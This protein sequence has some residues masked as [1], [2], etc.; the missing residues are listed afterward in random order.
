MTRDQVEGEAVVAV[1]QR[2]HAEEAAHLQGEEDPGVDEPRGEAVA[3]QRPPARTR[4]RD[5]AGFLVEQDDGPGLCD[6][7]HPPI[8]HAP[9]PTGAHSVVHG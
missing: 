1:E 5:V 4:R 8:L 9:D 7:G 2:R 6:C 3:D